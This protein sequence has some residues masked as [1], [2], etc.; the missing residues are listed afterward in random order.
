MEFNPAPFTRYFG[1]QDLPTG[2]RKDVCCFQ[3]D[4][5]HILAYNGVKPLKASQILDASL[6]SLPVLNSAKSQLEI[7][8]LTA[9]FLRLNL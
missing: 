3:I 2:P 6:V 8:A 7:D 1:H 9:P 5:W 4:S